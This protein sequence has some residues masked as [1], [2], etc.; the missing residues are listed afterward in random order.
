VTDI[1]LEGERKTFPEKF[2]Y[3]LQAF[4][5]GST[6]RIAHKTLVGMK[7]RLERCKVHQQQQ[8]RQIWVRA[9]PKLAQ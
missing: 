1:H 6:I 2:W 5:Y 3:A 4:Q 9:A 8:Q 7:Y